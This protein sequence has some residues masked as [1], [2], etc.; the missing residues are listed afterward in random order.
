MLA[1]LSVKNFTL[2]D[3]LE[4]ELEPGMTVITG[5]TGA[6]KSILL[7]ALGLTLGDRADAGR[8]RHGSDRADICATFDLVN[9]PGAK[10]WLREHDLDNNSDNGPDNHS[11]CLLRRTL[12]SDGRSRGYINGRP[13]PLAQLRELGELLL[14]LHSQ[15][16]HQSLL[17]KDKHRQLLD[18]FAG[19]THLIDQCG[20]QF[21]LWQQHQKVFEQHRDNAADLSARVQLLRYQ[22]Q[23]LDA[24]SLS[25]GEV[26]QLEEEQKQ[27]SGAEELLQECGK[28]MQLCDDDESG[29][30]TLLGRANHILEQ[31]EHLPERLCSARDLLASAD[32]QMREAQSDLSHF[33][34]SFEADPQHLKEIEDRLSAAYTIARKHRIDPVELPQLHATLSEELAQLDGGEATLDDLLLIAQRARRDWLTTAQRLSSQRSKAAKKLEKAVNLQLK[35]LAMPNAQLAVAVT[36][37]E[38]QEAAHGIDRI[39]LL[40]STNPGQPPRPLAKVASGGELSRISLAIQVVTVQGT[41]TASLVFDEVDVGIGGATADVVGKLLRTL[42]KGTQVICVTHLPQV[43]SKG[44]QHLQVQKESNRRSAQSTLKKLTDNERTLEIARMLGGED[45]TERTRE[46]AEEM[47]ALVGEK[48]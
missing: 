28:V 24:L 5:E 20:Q 46:H 47:L 19:H 48:D 11:E 32:I 37:D 30:L 43:A 1:H 3:S 15:H 12:T 18:D 25:N 26:Q 21:A 2:V 38:Q 44:H 9:S 27:L 16:E 6:G 33:I 31:I 34:D 13:V 40:V 35:Q 10:S 36:A 22:V 42:S 14:E 29:L 45:I 39:E 7:D 17:K 41:D 23:E 4:L 8:I